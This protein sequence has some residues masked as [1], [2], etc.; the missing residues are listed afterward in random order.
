LTIASLD[1][2]RPFTGFREVRLVNGGF[3]NTHVIALVEFN[4]PVQ[5]FS[6]MEFLQ[7]ECNI[8]ISPSYVS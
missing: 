2:F 1:L 7:G 8:I 4:T 6:A 5:A 3:D